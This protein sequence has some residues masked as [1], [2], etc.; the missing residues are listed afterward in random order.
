[1]ISLSASIVSDAGSA[2]FGNGGNTFPQV[3]VAFAAGEQLE[4]DNGLPV[5]R[6]S[7]PLRRYGACLKA[8][9]LLAWMVELS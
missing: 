9:C 1:M 5:P 8:A 4:Q 2:P 6:R 7:F 3:A